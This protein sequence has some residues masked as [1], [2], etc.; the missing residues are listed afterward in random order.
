[1][2]S[3]EQT[4]QCMNFAIDVAVQSGSIA[5]KNFRIPILISNKASEGT[6]D[7]VTEA[8]REIESYIRERIS[9]V[10]PTHGIIGEEHDDKIGTENCTWLVDPIDGTCGYVIG[11]PMWGSLLG[12]LDEDKCALGLM[13]QPFVQ[14]TYIGSADG[15]YIIDRN[16]KRKIRTS[17]TRDIENAVLCCTHQSIL[18]SS[19]VQDA[20]GRVANA[21]RFSRLGTDCWG[22]ALLAHGFVDIVIENELKAYDAVPLI[23]IVE[24]AGGLMTDWDGDA[25]RAGGRVV[26][27]A[28]A[29]LHEKVL[30]LIDRSV[31]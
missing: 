3:K 1:V 26:A 15:A 27:S 29:V 18:K 2:L 22:Y 21:C 25:V 14:E 30:K 4:R 28:N 19:Q 17:D 12:L 11:S 5:M 16:G 24:S 13:H 31:D 10:Y 20:Y 23:P 8:D 6:F 9:E 7:P